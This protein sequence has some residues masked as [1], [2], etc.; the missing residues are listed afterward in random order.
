MNVLNHKSFE[1]RA[2]FS[3]K[4][5]VQYILKLWIEKWNWS[6][7]KKVKVT[8]VFLIWRHTL[9]LGS[10]DFMFVSVHY[11][12][13][14]ISLCPVSECKA[15]S[16]LFFVRLYL[17]SKLSELLKAWQEQLGV[18]CIWFYLLKVK[19]THESKTNLMK[20]KE[21]SGK[22]G[23]K[24]NILK[25]KIMASSHITSWEI[26]GETMETV[27]DFILGGSK[28]TAD[29]DFS[30]EISLAKLIQLCKV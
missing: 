16:H 1:K 3:L 23:L 21:K 10:V 14:L 11:M 4:K 27:I 8:P 20:V 6:I 2:I 24:I 12:Y 13:I 7:V 26:D 5:C 28:I 18:N 17:T 19:L 22:T 9:L 25:T 29:G 15:Q 30:H